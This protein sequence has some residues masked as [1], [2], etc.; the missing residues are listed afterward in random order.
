MAECYKALINNKD[1]F[2]ELY[3]KDAQKANEIR[4]T[5]TPKKKK[6]SS[7]A[8]SEKPPKKIATETK[9]KP[10]PSPIPPP[11]V[12]VQNAIPAQNIPKPTWYTVKTFNTFLSED[13]TPQECSAFLTAVGESTFFWTFGLSE[14][15][16]KVLIC[17]VKKPGGT[18]NEGTRIVV[19]IP[20]K[21]SIKDTYNFA[22]EFAN[23]GGELLIDYR[24]FTSLICDDATVKTM[25]RAA[26][27][28]SASELKK[29]LEDNDYVLEVG[30]FLQHL[31]IGVI[32][33]DTYCF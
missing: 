13:P 24:L 15:G 30:P 26:S 8:V 29:W 31:Y 4:G 2:D 27:K 1:F 16:N 25:L 3:R 22:F 23:R 11:S 19:G 7:K 10:E 32:E 21:L 18:F 12:F 14:S 5:L 17:I 20:I 33:A 28:N 9:Q 6:S